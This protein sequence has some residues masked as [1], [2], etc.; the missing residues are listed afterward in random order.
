[1]N[2]AEVQYFINMA[3]MEVRGGPLFANHVARR[4]KGYLMTW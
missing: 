2:M 3:Y 1:M 4:H